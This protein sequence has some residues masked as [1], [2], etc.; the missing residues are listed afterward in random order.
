[1]VPTESRESIGTASSQPQSAPRLRE[2]EVG[3]RYDGWG[4]QPILVHVGYPKSGSTYLQR[5]LFHNKSGIWYPLDRDT[6]T[7]VF[8][9][10]D[11]L[12]FDADS[13][14]TR[15]EQTVDWGLASHRV[16]VISHEGL[17]NIA[18]SYGTRTREIADRLWETFGRQ[19]RVLIVIREQCALILS[20]F[21]QYRKHGGRLSLRRFLAQD[22]IQ[23]WS[24]PVFRF[25]LYEYDRAL[26]YYRQRFGEESV[27]MLALEQLK[28][29]PNSFFHAI[30]DMFDVKPER[31]EIPDPKIRHNVTALS[32][33]QLLM[34]RWS[35]KFSRPRSWRPDTHYIRPVLSGMVALERAAGAIVPERL[36]AGVR[37]RWAAEV[38]GA[39]GARYAASN[40]R[41]ADMTGLPLDRLGYVMHNDR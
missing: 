3:R 26:C 21:A 29:E 7:E 41:L 19:A 12:G 11:G 10:P 40:R 4:E 6:V 37:S 13:A 18:G 14:R 32:P 38:A 33:V 17:M 28:V 24:A 34:R 2:D 31:R 25:K 39:A 1:M 35:T 27:L 30:Y 20:H 16:P 36:N 9:N 22:A 15:M 23:D 8:I 5:E